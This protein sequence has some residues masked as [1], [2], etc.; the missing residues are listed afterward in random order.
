M[1][2]PPVNEPDD[3][4]P[5]AGRADDIDIGRVIMLH[6]F[7][8]S[9]DVAFGHDLVALKDH[10]VRIDI[11]ALMSGWILLS[12]AEMIEWRRVEIYGTKVDTTNHTKV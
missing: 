5:F 1:L 9:L 12:H 11:N 7:T 2:E 3:N 10:I 6:A 4:R 8:G